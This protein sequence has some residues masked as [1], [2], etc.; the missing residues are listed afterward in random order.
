MREIPVTLVGR[1]T[2]LLVRDGGI[3]GVVVH[4]SSEEFS[5]IEVDGERVIVRGGARLRSVVNAA[6]KHELG[7]LEFLEGIPGSLGVRCG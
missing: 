7:G 2:N 3:P 6:K 5:K 4:L 1:G